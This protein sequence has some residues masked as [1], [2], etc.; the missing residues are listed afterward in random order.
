ML[1]F[2]L[3]RRIRITDVVFVRPPGGWRAA[4]WTFTRLR[5]PSWCSTR[6]RPQSSGRR[7]TPWSENA[8]SVRR[9]E[10][11]TIKYKMSC[12]SVYSISLSWLNPHVTHLLVGGLCRIRLKSLNSHTD[13]SSLARKVVEECRLIHPSKLGEVEQLLFYLKNRKIANGSR[14]V[15]YSIPQR[16]AEDTLC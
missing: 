10:C 2:Y 16:R 15:F 14:D 7:G 6:W 4:L 1:L 5:K 3:I 9:R 11:H 8:K 12:C 13:T